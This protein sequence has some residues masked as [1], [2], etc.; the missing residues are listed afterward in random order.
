M[1]GLDTKNQPWTP[2]HPLPIYIP[3][4]LD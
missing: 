3:L 2:F 4:W 1:V